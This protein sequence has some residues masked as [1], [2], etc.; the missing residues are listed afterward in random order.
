[1]KLFPEGPMSSLSVMV[2]M[3]LKILWLVRDNTKQKDEMSMKKDWQSV[4][5]C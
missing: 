5:R 2:F 3:R 4:N 1:M